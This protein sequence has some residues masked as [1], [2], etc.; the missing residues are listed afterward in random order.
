MSDQEALLHAENRNILYQYQML[1]TD[2][3]QMLENYRLVLKQRDMLLKAVSGCLKTLGDTLNEQLNASDYDKLFNLL[4][5]QKN[6]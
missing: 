6:E 1:Q 2:Y 3:K 5:P 4:K